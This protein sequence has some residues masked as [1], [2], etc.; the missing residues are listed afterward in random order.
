M[1]RFTLAQYERKIQRWAKRMPQDAKKAMETVAKDNAKEARQRHLSGPRMPVGQTSDKFPTIASGGSLRSSVVHRVRLTPGKD[2][3]A[4]IMARHPLAQIHHE[5]A[6]LT[7]TGDKPFVFTLP[8]SDRRIVTRTVRIPARPF[9]LAPV[10][11]NRKRTLTRLLKA[12]AMGI[13]R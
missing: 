6:V 7:A 10:E 4:Q 5:G 9:L 2:I 12:M 8:G 13:K 11:R 3:K 1:G